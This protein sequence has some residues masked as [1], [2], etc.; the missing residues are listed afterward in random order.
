MGV[1]VAVTAGAKGTNITYY[2][3]LSGGKLSKVATTA[4]TCTAPATSVSWNSV[5]PTGPAG[6]SVLSGAGAPGINLGAIG[7]FY[8]D[9]STYTIYGPAT[10][11]CKP[12]CEV[13]WGAGTSL[14]GQGFVYDTQLAE[15]LLDANGASVRVLTQTLASGGNFEV[16]ARVVG[17]ISNSG[18]SIVPVY[19]QTDWNCALVAANPGG[20][21]ITLDTNQEYGAAP[22]TQVELQGVVSLAPGG[23]V[24]INCDE[25]DDLAYDNFTNARITSTQVGGFTTVAPG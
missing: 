1:I 2:A 15:P 13:D 23:F 17:L 3:C 11:V 8:I 18:G 5:G 6:T 19:D 25:T 24:G 21:T 10:R 16:A 20:S 9:T 14:K 4:P 22:T 12:K 7:D